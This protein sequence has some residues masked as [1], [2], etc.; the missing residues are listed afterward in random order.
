MKN[1]TKTILDALGLHKSM[2][3]SGEQP[4]DSSNAAFDAAMEAV[5]CLDETAIEAMMAVDV[6]NGDIESRYHDL[7]YYDANQSDQIPL[8]QLVFTYGG[9]WCAIEFEG[10]P[11]WSSEGEGTLY[12]DDDNQLPLE[13]YL[14]QEVAKRL[15]TLREMPF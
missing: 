9:T 1:I 5:K 8:P 2:A 15:Q 12:D 14:R 13:P 7:G 4:T 10:F 6:I 3:L 11:I